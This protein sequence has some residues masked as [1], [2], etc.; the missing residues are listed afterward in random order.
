MKVHII[1][2]GL[3]GS[4]AAWQVAKRGVEVVLHEMR[5]KKFSPAHKTANFAE[6]VCS[7][8]L[9]A[10]GLTNAVGVL[11]EE[12]R[13]LDSAI[14][15]AAD[16]AK[17]PAG[18]ALAVDREEFGK[19]VTEKIKSVANV[20]EEEITSLENFSDDVTIIASGPLTDGALADE[21]KRLTSGDD[22]YF[23]DAAAPIVTVDSIDFGK[24][25]KASRYGKGDDDAY[26]N[27]PMTRD[28]YLTFRA[29]LIA[30][31][32]TKPHEFETEIFFEGC[33]PVEVLA[34]RGEDTM[35]FGNLKPVGLPD[36]RTGQIPYAVVQLRQDNRAA[37]LYN[38][39]GFQ[40][41]LTWP[42]QR[43]VFRMIPGLEAAEFVRY[44]VMHRNTFI[45]SP[46]LLSPTFQ[47][48]SAPKIFFAGQI[49]GVEGYVESA[50]SG[51]VAG[52][53]AARL[54]KNLEP[55]IFPPTTCH[56]A[57]ANY[58]T[59]ADEKNFQPMNVTFGLLPPLEGRTPKKFR[60]EKLATRALDD[61]KIFCNET[62]L[63]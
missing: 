4:E 24:A 62:E 43:R 40:T 60:K 51:L 7:N 32:K 35:R 59:T 52:I 42:E 31:E 13:Q 23:Y 53:N 17:I 6:L 25:F 49:T 48:K 41:H 33:L 15:S 16:A 14:M 11:K 22:F 46:K 28:E 56:G 27:C 37:T 58:I 8:S 57:L 50:A 19:L 45:N 30:A 36:P 2:A 12:M 39:V 54:A 18:G 21:I 9:R 38:L 1:G 10:A 63:I 5:P 26:I 3:A 47:L 44:G 20:V 34:A 55:L 61:L 29:E